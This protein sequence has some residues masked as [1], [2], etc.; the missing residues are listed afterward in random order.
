MER[1]GQ[2]TRF[3]CLCLLSAGMTDVCDCATMSGLY[4]VREALSEV[5]S[6]LSTHGSRDR[7]LA[8]S[9][10]R[11]LPCAL[12]CEVQPRKVTFLCH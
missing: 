11:P 1:R 3:C 7:T 9:S 4:V 8:E 6:L 10:F 12:R 2:D 5:G